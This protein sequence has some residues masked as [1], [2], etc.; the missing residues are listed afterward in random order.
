MEK[1]NKGHFRGEDKRVDAPEKGQIAG[2]KSQSG[3]KAQKKDP[4]RKADSGNKSKKGWT[5]FIRKAAGGMAVLFRKAAGGVAA[6]FCSAGRGIKK[7]WRGLPEKFHRDDD[8]GETEDRKEKG[9]IK[10]LIEKVKGKVTAKEKTKE[11]VKETEKVTAKEKTNVK[12]NVKAKESGKG[13]R[14]SIR[15]KILIAVIIPIFFII[16]VGT[17]SYIKAE[18]GMRTKYEKSTQEAMKM[19]AAQV[20]LFSTFIKGEASRY[21]Y[22]R[23]LYRIICGLYDE[24]LYAKKVAVDNVNA[25]V[26][27]SQAGNKFIKHIHIIPKAG[28]KIFS[29]KTTAVDGFFDDL[30]AGATDPENSRNVISWVDEHPQIDSEL[31]LDATRRDAYVFSYQAL[32]ETRSALVVVD[33]S[34]DAVQEFLDNIDLGQN[35]VVGLITMNGKEVLR[36]Q[37]LETY[38]E[39]HVFTGEKYYEKAQQEIAAGSTEGLFEVKFRKKPGLF[40]YS[41]CE[42]SGSVVCGIVPMATVTAEATEIKTLTF[43]IVLIALLIA[44]TIGIL[45]TVAIQKNLKRVARGLGEVAKGDLTVAVRASGN[46]EFQDLAVATTGMIKN[47]KKLVSKVEHASE[48]LAQS[49]DEVQKASTVLGECSTDISEAVSDMSNGMERQMRHAKECVSITDSLSDEIRNVS[50]QIGMI[51]EVI[52]QTGNMINEGVGLANTLGEKAKDTTEATD[53]V[54]DSVQA[55]LAETSKINGFVDVIKNISSQTH[56]LSLNASIEA[57]RAGDAGRG[58]GVVAEEIRKLAT[59]S[60]GAAG[61]IN[62]LVDR[63]NVQ[64]SS[65]TESVDRARSIA[66]EQFE[67]VNQSVDI[68]SRMQDSM[69][70]LTIELGNIVS[71][72]GAAD[73]RRAETVNAVRDIAGIIEDSAENAKAVMEVLEQ[74]K[75]NVE[76]LD[77]TAGALG[78]SMDELKTEVAV[79]K[80]QKDQ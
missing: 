48:G 43:L 67:L 2:G 45:I 11:K 40:F 8:A 5:V 78:E 80:I 28:N 29:T 38:G 39:E 57:A 59:E 49:A 61:E 18:E 15:Y 66:D 24:D 68:F 71:A 72:T 33:V 16:V 69:E 26:L 14:F 32:T 64:M 58:F 34:Q 37:D 7:I 21:A 13:L 70:K 4:F 77:H 52:G 60:A 44:F 3:V 20:D 65:S 54:K 19:A 12:E 41:Y 17:S 79:F 25:G 36:K 53:S 51:K 55:L 27:S 10:A 76:H 1:N 75:A 42:V 62:K 46:D 23:E 30:I 56:L 50:G 22:D 63:I 6:F 74:L 9:K 31:K 35:C 73:A 47:T